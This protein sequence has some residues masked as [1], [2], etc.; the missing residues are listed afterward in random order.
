[1]SV[2]AQ[3]C[4]RVPSSRWKKDATACGSCLSDANAVP[5]QPSAPWSLAASESPLLRCQSTPEAF[6]TVALWKAGVIPRCAPE[7]RAVLRVA[8]QHVIERQ[9]IRRSYQPAPQLPVQKAHPDAGAFRIW[10]LMQ[11]VPLDISSPPG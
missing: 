6:R 4:K 5:R 7:E 8:V 1:L 2:S 10:S 11:G 3:V 9:V